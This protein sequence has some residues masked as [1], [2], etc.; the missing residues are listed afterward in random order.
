MFSSLQISTIFESLRQLPAGV[1]FDWRT[2]LDLIIVAVLAYGFLVLI[3]RS[4]AR[5]ILSGLAILLAIYLVA[6]MLNLY[7]T[8]LLFQTFFTFFVVI[9]VIIFQREWRNFF[10]WLYV[11]GRLPRG[12]RLTLP[13]VL[14]QQL[15]ETV[16]ILNTRRMGALIV[17]PGLQP[18][19]SLIQGGVLLNG[20]V[21]VP[22]LLS[23]FDTSS[24]GHDGAV[25]LDGDRVKKFGTHLP[26]A[27]RFDA[28]LG[29]RHRAAVGL[30]QRS[31]ALVVVVSEE[32]GTVSIA[33]AGE[34][35]T[36]PSPQGIEQHVREMFLEQFGSRQEA[37]H[38]YSFVTHNVREK[39][40]A[41]V[42]TFL[43]WFLLVAQGGSGI[44]TRD[45]DV[46]IELRLVSADYVLTRVAPDSIEVTLSGRNQ[47]FLLF[48]NTSL[49]VTIP[50]EGG[51]G[52]KTLKISREHIRHPSGLT[53][54]Q[55]SPDTIK[56]FLEEQVSR[57]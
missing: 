11:W 53:V 25:I 14:T 31:D 16:T 26:L 27:E 46:P 4:H 45:F 17:L 7:L 22:L 19:D 28:A 12:R 9:I 48:D 24:P 23:I 55:F 32:R 2:S 15:I 40:M 1:V 54:V 10:E 37:S 18:V 38:W 47:D 56:I 8:S 36:L 44:V 5:S 20:K 49:K 13:D 50:V 41:A 35:T 30:S 52:E 3:K 51:A 6:R 33:H 34:L 57:E 21:S 39:I 29:T 43:F 42:F